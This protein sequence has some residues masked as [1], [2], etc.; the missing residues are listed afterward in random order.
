MFRAMN[1]S[2]VMSKSQ[3]LDEIGNGK[4]T[5]AILA[6]V[7]VLCALV[8][9]LAFAFHGRHIGQNAAAMVAPG[10]GTLVPATSGSAPVGSPAAH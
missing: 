10:A 7:L 1:D 4:R 5:G 3:R 6:A 8:G 2:R 9:V